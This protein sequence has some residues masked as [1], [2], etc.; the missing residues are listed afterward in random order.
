MGWPAALAQ[1]GAHLEVVKQYT[2][3]G[4]VAPEIDSQRQIP[5]LVTTT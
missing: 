2:G 1:N 4:H 3:K 5:S